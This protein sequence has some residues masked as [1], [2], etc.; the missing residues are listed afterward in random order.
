MRFKIGDKAIMAKERD[1]PHWKGTCVIIERFV[2]DNRVRVRTEGTD[3]F[4]GEMSPSHR[5]HR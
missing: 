3:V 2:T 5:V 4:R 1:W